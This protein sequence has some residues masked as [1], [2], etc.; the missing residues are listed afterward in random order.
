MLRPCTL[1]RINDSNNIIT[2]STLFINN[3]DFENN[4]LV[5]NPTNGPSVGVHPLYRCTP[6]RGSSNCGILSLHNSF[7]LFA[8]RNVSA[9]LR[10]RSDPWIHNKGVR[11]IAFQTRQSK[12]NNPPWGLI[13]ETATVPDAELSKGSSPLFFH[14]LDRYA[15]VFSKPFPFGQALIMINISKDNPVLK[16]F[17]AFFFYHNIGYL[18]LLEGERVICTNIENNNPLSGKQQTT[19]TGWG[20]R[21]TLLVDNISA[22]EKWQIQQGRQPAFSTLH[23]QLDLDVN[24]GRYRKLPDNNNYQERM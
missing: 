9:S 22:D 5:I 8:N 20:T 11:R 10:T 23:S 2:N 18:L 21:N 19:T 12:N 6:I 24:W 7:F 1:R 3:I 16:K 15:Y 14:P 13:R 4:Y 17:L